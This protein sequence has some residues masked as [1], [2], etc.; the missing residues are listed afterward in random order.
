MYGEIQLDIGME[1]VNLEQFKNAVKDYN[2]SRGRVFKWVKNDKLRARAKCVG[3]G[4]Q[5]MI[6]CGFN[7]NRKSFQIKTFNSE[8]TCCREFQNKRL[9][10]IG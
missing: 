3:E 5:W 2:I 9:I 10:Q 8:H 4:C 7:S 6:F 1:F